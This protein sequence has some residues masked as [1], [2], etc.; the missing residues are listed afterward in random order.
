[1]I[2]H[3]KTTIMKANFIKIPKMSDVSFSFRAFRQPNVN[4]S[5]HFHEELEL[6]HILHG[7]GTQFIGDHIQRFQADDI[8]LLG[9]NL[10][11]FWRYDEDVLSEKDTIYSTNIHFNQHLWGQGFMEMPENTLLKKMMEESKR[12]LLL[13]GAL[14]NQVATWMEKIQASEGTFRLIHLLECLTFISLDHGTEVIPLASVGFEHQTSMTEDDRI[15]AIYDFAFKHFKEP[16]SLAM[17]A[18]EV[19]FAP[20]AFCRYFKSKTGKS[21]TEFITEFRVSQACKLLIEG[22][23]NNKQ[24][25]YES[26]FHNTSSFHKHF[27][28]ITGMSP[29]NYQNLFIKS[30]TS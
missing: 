20:S 27:K 8:I 15:N 13:K 16:I 30:K 2:W 6:I 25:C 26:G 28:L 1:M 23:I 14:R 29:Q 4:S 18:H 11:H 12:G 21:F 24:I 19:G 7:H 3:E 17:V 22:K 10:P 9:S 5:W